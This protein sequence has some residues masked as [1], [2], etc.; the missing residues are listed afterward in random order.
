MDSSSEDGPMCQRKVV[1]GRGVTG[2]I[3]F[4]INARSL[5]LEHARVEHE[6]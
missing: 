1:S 5:H 6:A 2:V 3:K 4:L